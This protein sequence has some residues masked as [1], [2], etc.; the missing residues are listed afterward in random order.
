MKIVRN[1]K[2]NC[3]KQTSNKF[4][5]SKIQSVITQFWVIPQKSPFFRIKI[6][7]IK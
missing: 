1:S 4:L 5:S 7:K 6:K 2:Q 3:L